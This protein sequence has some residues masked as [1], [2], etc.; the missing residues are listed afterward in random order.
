MN[1][2]LNSTFNEEANSLFKVSD[3]DKLFEDNC[4]L[5][6]EMVDTHERV[7]VPRLE[8]LLETYLGHNHGINNRDDRDSE[9]AD[10][11]ATHD[12]AK[13]TVDFITGYVGGNPI[14]YSLENQKNQEQINAF[15]DVNDIEA[16]DYNMIEDCGIYGRA[17]EL[18]YRDENEVDKVVQVSPYEAFC[19]RDNTLEQNVIGG[20]THYKEKNVNDRIETF[21]TLYTSEMKHEFKK[22]DEGVELLKEQEHFYNDVQL[23]EWWA[24]RFRTCDFEHV[25]DLFDLYDI[26]QSDTANYMTDLNDAML[27]IEG[28]VD[29]T[30]EEAKKMKESRIIL[31]KTKPD[32]DGKVGNVNI[33][34]IYKQYDVQGVESYKDRL[35]QDIHLMTYTPDL[36]DENFSGVQSGEAMKYK[37]TSLEQLR[38]KKERMFKKALNKR[39]KLLGRILGIQNMIEDDMDKVK[40]EFTPNV[41]K[42]R[43]EMVELFT[44][45]GGNL[46]ERT[47]LQLLDFVDDIDAEQAQIDKERTEAQER[48]P[49]VYEAEGSEE[50]EENDNS[51]DNQNDDEDDD[52][53]NE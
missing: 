27:K 47:K 40:I 51:N 10:Y 26:A 16:H 2:V 32:A 5:L 29:L 43:K 17:Y 12:F 53:D 8:R 44:S 42:T 13:Y 11:R 39:Y 35:K 19:I 4:K 6:W 37:L 1:S 31:G 52:S 50:D 36:S 3:I 23:N 49:D 25:L 30:T 38:A 14:T 46:S 9:L 33:D 34:Y 28:N 24:N 41:P 45:L 48:Q 18:I 20:V 7:Q 22:G 15:N 21:F